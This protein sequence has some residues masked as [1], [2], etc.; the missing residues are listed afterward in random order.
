MVIRV[1]EVFEYG[2]A[3][4]SFFVCYYLLFYLCIYIIIIIICICI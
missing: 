1:E 2:K 4:Q 3:H